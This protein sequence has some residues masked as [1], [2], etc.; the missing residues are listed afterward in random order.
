ME[1]VRLRKICVVALSITC[2]AIAGCQGLAPSQ[3][4]LPSHQVR[5][6]SAD[7]PQQFQEEEPTSEPVND[8]AAESNPVNNAEKILDVRIKGNRLVPTHH[9]LR[10]I[11][12]RPGRFFDP[13]LLQQD[14]DQL[15][16]IK[17]VRRINGPFIERTEDGIIVTIEV[18]ERRY[19]DKVK[20]IG[21]RAVSDWKLKQQVDIKAGDPLDLHQVRMAKQ[22][23]EQYYHENGYPRTQVEI[24]QGADTDDR[25]VVFS[26]S[27]DRKQLISKVDFVG[28]SV[29]SDARLLTQIKSKPTLLGIMRGSLNRQEVEQD[30]LRLTSYYRALGYFNA[31]IGREIIENESGSR[32]RIRFIIDEG[33]RYRIRSVSFMGNNQF[34]AEQL[35]EL[36]KLKPAAGEMPEFRSAYM[37]ADVTSLRDLY[38]SQGYAF[39][40]V[41]AEPRFLEEPGYL[42]LVYRID[43]G[44][45]YRVGKINI[46]IDGDY[47]VTQREVILNRLALQP[48]DILDARKVR[49]TE[50]LLRGSKVFADGSPGTG[51]PPRVTVRPPE[52]EQ[53][54]RMAEGERSRY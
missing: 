7:D 22:R 4:V 26:I 28:N 35:T 54:Q 45:Q 30:L 32:A 18:M 33:P 34:D 36:L 49:D 53:I 19:I 31:R 52:L 2:L 37:N 15:W 3:G 13:D 46:H 8:A 40:N 25:D 5:Y 51:P 50:R 6:Q 24:V 1:A 9:L 42:D 23:I 20:F 14:V 47:G 48:G 44:K 11:R 21:N 41:Q 17:E 43:E 29:A 16:Q 38:L 39:V 27:E 12:T 10:S